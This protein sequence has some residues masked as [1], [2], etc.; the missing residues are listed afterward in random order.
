MRHRCAPAT[1]RGAALLA[2]RWGRRA[3][4]ACGL[5]SER[6]REGGGGCGLGGLK[7]R[8]QAHLWRS[9][10]E[11]QHLPADVNA[12]GE[13]RRRRAEWETVCR[14][15]DV[16]RV[17][18]AGSHRGEALHHGEVGQLRVG[19]VERGREHAPGAV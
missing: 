4:C 8:G 19:C 7:G 14:L 9:S 13:R 2:V 10:L 6:R 16:E 17:E 15:R 11:R 5:W 1:R 18:V 12:P 3:C